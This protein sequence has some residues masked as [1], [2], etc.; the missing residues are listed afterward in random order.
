[1]KGRGDW[2]R[3][4]RS[5]R[6][7]FLVPAYV[8]YV[9]SEGENSEP[10]YVEGIKEEAERSGYILKGSLI[11]DHS[12]RARQGDELI[13][14][15]ETK[16]HQYQKD[17]LFKHKRIA[18]VWIFFD[19]DGGKEAYRQ[20]FAGIQRLNA[21]E[22]K[23]KAEEKIRW[24]A[25]WSSYC[26][27]EWLYLHFAYSETAFS[28]AELEDKLSKVISEEGTSYRY[29]K[30]D[31]DIFSRVYSPARV[32]AAIHRSK[33]LNEQAEK[34]KDPHRNPSTGVGDFVSFFLKNES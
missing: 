31:R 4:S 28:E 29:S 6:G 3:S 20:A 8:N 19:F 32:K 22:A 27:E 16:V 11:I 23:K 15:V 33:K 9:F 30:S 13:R 26:F 7:R 12:I 1:M 17:L 34:A 14:E 25:C 24:H 2:S 10:F 21:L 5:K 18:N